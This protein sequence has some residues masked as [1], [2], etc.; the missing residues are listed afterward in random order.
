MYLSQI[1]K[2]DNHTIY[3]RDINKKIS[4]NNSI[5]YSQLNKLIVQASVINSVT[6][7]FLLT[8]TRISI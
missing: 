2:H 8:I 1:F 6:N 7:V 4:N 3:S 5:N